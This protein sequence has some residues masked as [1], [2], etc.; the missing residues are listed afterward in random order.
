[1]SA[2]YCAVAAGQYHIVEQLLWNDV[3]EKHHLLPPLSMKTLCGR[4]ADFGG[5]ESEEVAS[6]LRN[7][8]TRIG[9]Y[10]M[11]SRLPQSERNRLAND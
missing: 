6:V 1:L 3:K 7:M 10:K 9:K 4:L 8:M 5:G 2:A 11:L